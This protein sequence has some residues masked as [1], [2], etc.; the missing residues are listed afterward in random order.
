MKKAFLLTTAAA[1]CTLL[2]TQFTA[3]A[4][5]AEVKITADKI[6]FIYDIKEFTVKAGQ[7]VKLTFINP[8]DSVNLQPHNLVIIKPGKLQAM[9]AVVNDPTKLSDPSW[10]K[11]PIPKEG[12]DVHPDI[13]HH[14]ALLAVGEE[15]VLEF[16]APD[17]PGDY[18]YLCTYV[19]H[20]ILMNGVMKVTK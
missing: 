3:Q 15:E 20:A 12:D 19:G 4:E 8:K 18:P 2:L 9:I 5:D 11:N 14:T 13:L 6:T 10:L 7:K 1:A 16:T 17:E